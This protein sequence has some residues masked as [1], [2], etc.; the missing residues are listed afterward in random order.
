MKPS[1]KLPDNTTRQNEVNQLRLLVKQWDSLILELDELNASL[2]ADIR[3]SSLTA[4]R[5][6]KTV[7]NDVTK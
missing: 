3:Q 6:G 4:Y 7:S 1:P 2:E 5:L